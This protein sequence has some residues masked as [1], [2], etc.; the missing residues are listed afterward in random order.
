M[1]VLLRQLRDE[2]VP[3]VVWTLV[4]SSLANYVASLYASGLLGGLEDLLATLP[5]TLRAFLGDLDI[6]G[7]DGWLNMEHFALMPLYIGFYAGVTASALIARE[8]DARSLELL[9]AQPVRRGYVLAGKFGSF[10]AGVVLIHL[11]MMAGL[12]WGI[13]RAG[14]VGNWPAYWLLA[15]NSMLV[16]LAIGAWCLL[17]SVLVNDQ[18]RAVMLG[19]GLVLLLFFTNAILRSS[20]RSKAFLSLLNPFGHY[21]SAAVLKTGSIPWGAVAWL[22]GSIAVALGMAAWTFSDKDVSF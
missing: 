9:L 13:A 6:K 5:P 7:L 15:L 2:L 20:G 11:G 14:E 10:A 18:R 1:K 19:S 3:L 22:A 17:I 12:A 16:A 4:L 8:A 21:D